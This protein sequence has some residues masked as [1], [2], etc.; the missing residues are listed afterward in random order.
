MSFHLMTEADYRALDADGLTT[1]KELVADMLDRAELPEGIT[2]E[3]LLAECS[4]IK[5][6]VTRRNAIIETR[7]AAI[8]DLKGG[9]GRVIETSGEKPES[10]ADVD[11]LDTKGY[12]LAFMAYCQRKSYESADKVYRTDPDTGTIITGST[13]TTG[14]PP[15]IPTTM[16]KEIVTKMESYGTIWNEVRK[17]Y[18][19]GGVDYRVLDLNPVATWVQDGVGASELTTSPYQGVT[20]DATISFKF[21]MVECRMSM[22]LLAQATTFEDFQALFVPAVAK[23]MVKALEQAIV[24]GNGTKKPLGLTVDPRITNVVEMTLEQMADWTKWHSMV[25]AEIPAEYEDGKF[26]F[27]KKF[28]N[29]VID[30]LKDD[31][32]KP[33]GHTHF[34]PVSGKRV[35]TFMGYPAEL[36][37]T[38]ILPDP[39]VNA[40][41]DGTVFGFYGNLENYV[42]NVQPGMPMTI[43]RWVDD[44][45]NVEKI[46]GLMACDGKVLDPYGF[47]L[48][49]VD[50]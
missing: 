22:S 5:A 18:L 45:N 42:C 1:R 9:I 36:L 47:M 46:K 35:T 12:R 29:K 34:D 49:K 32:N 41:T 10:I 3:A 16:Q 20:N 11:P 28:W 27:A 30:T 17:L 44:D 19:K 26:Y 6:E 38:D 8:A 40:T 39:T 31:D 25:D 14:V 4:I 15:Q 48:L 21:Y 2:T 24:R 37:S 23:A 50:K 33:I 43:K 7:N 13:V